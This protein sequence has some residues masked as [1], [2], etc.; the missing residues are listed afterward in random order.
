MKQVDY[1]RDLAFSIA[2]SITTTAN[3][4]STNSIDIESANG[5]QGTPLK[6]VINVTAVAASESMTVKVCSKSADSVAAT[7]GTYTLPAITAVGQYHHTLPQD[8]ARYVK[9]FYTAGTSATVTAYLTAE[10]V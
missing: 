3:T 1:D 7:D 6:V 5:G 4:A 10:I 9:L 8:S 2:Q